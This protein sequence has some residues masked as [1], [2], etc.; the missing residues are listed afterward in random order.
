M[1]QVNQKKIKTI[2]EN[3]KEKLS[4]GKPQYGL[5][6]LRK[7]EILNVFPDLYNSKKVLKWKSKISFKKGLNITINSLKKSL[8]K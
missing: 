1:D 6:K 5:I 7:D 2:I 4:G 3:I 8:Q